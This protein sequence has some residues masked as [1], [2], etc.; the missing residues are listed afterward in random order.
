MDIAIIGAGASGM[1]AAITASERE[2]NRITV[3]EKSDRVGRKI[4]AS[5]NGR[6]NFTNANCSEAYYHG[7]GIVLFNEINTH[8][9]NQDTVKW[10]IDKKLI[11]ERTN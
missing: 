3:F 10:F 1:M 7:S 5:G 4:L 2:E 8:F 9:N 11:Y 6:C